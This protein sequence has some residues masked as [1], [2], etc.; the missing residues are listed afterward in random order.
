[1][2]V[3]LFNKLKEKCPPFWRKL[4]K[5][6]GTALCGTTGAAFLDYLSLALTIRT[7]GVLDYGF[8]V[9]AQQYMTIIDNLANFQ[10]WSAIIKFGSDA[11]ADKNESKLL[12]TIKGGYCVDIATAVLGV[13]LAIAL[14]PL[15]GFLLNWGDELKFAALIFSLT[16]VSHI[17]GSSIGV[18]RLFDKFKWTA[19]Q[20]VASSLF[21]LG[22]LAMYVFVFKAPGGYLGFACVYVLADVVKHLSLLV[23][24]LIFVSKRFGLIRILT[25]PF[26]HLDRKFFKFCLWSNLGSSVD[27]PVKYLDV[28]IVELVS[29]E[30]VGIYKAYK[31]VLQ[32]FVTLTNPISVA[33]MPQVAELVSHGKA[34]RGYHVVLKIRNLVLSVLV[35]LFVCLIFFSSPILDFLLGKGFGDHSPLFL[36]L[37]LLSIISIS[38]VGLHPFFLALG[39]ARETSLIALTANV[40]YLCIAF[41]LVGIIGVWSVVLATAIQYAISISSKLIIVRMHLKKERDLERQNEESEEGA[42]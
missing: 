22:V 21:K 37:F 15:I 28:Y 38:Y 42:S 5:N 7:L 20:A 23:I 33:L 18:L 12:A 11:R 17:E 6:A 25:T 29:V 16:I 2:N 13:L 9:L 10:S 41:S 40:I 34:M 32:L 27:V 30:M 35:P 8:F 26:R 31:Q 36:T 14:V 3:P 4:A 39:K 24:S 19:Y 1:M